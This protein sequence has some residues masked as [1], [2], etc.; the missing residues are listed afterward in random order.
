MFDEF[1]QPYR[2]RQACQVC[3]TPANAA[4]TNSI[5]VSRRQAMLSTACGFGYLAMAGLAQRQAAAANPLAIKTPHF[6]PRA[7]RVIFLFMQGGPSH[8]DSFDYKP[9]LNNDHGQ[10]V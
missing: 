1:S 2:S 5:H 9:R 4:A 8:V 3:S 7:K 6:A 10:L